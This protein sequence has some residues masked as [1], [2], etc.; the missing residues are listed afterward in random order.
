MC[1]GKKH[2]IYSKVKQQANKSIKIIKFKLS[3]R[4]TVLLKKFKNFLNVFTR[5]SCLAD[6]S[7]QTLVWKV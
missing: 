7:L 3:S 2:K 6:C 1:K 5:N 4:L